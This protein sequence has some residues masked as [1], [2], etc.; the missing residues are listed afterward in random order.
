MACCW[1]YG[2]AA[3]QYG[4]ALLRLNTLHLQARVK[5]LDEEEGAVLGTSARQQTA[6]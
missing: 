5:E 2:P 1:P 3:G 6:A 4:R